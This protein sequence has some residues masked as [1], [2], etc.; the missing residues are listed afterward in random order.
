[1]L[2]NR[3][4]KLIVWYGML[5]TT[6]ILLFV[7]IAPIV[8]SSTWLCSNDF[9]TSIEISSTL[10]ALMVGFTCMS[11][12]YGLKHRFLFIIGLGFTLCGSGD[13]LHGLLPLQHL[14]VSFGNN[15]ILRI[16]D[17]YVTSRIFLAIM[18]LLALSRD[19]FLDDRKQ[20]PM[21]VFVYSF[22]AIIL[23][24]GI[25]QLS[26]LLPARLEIVSDKFVVRPVDLL[27][28]TLL[29]VAFLNL[30][31]RF[32]KSTD[33]FKG[34]L[35]AS[36]VCNLSGQIYMAFSSR[37]NDAYFSIAHIA[38][39]LS[40][41]MPLIGILIQGM[42]EINT[43]NLEIQKREAAQQ[44]LK[45]SEANYRSII[46]NIRD[47]F[48]RTDLN[49]KLTMI[50]PS[51]AKLCGYQSVDDM[52]GLDF[53]RDMYVDPAQRSYFLDELKKHGEVINYEV[54]LK[55]MDGS[56]LPV[57][58]N[59]HYRMDENGTPLYVEGILVDITER[60]KV[61]K[62]LQRSETKFRTLYE[63]TTD[64]VMLLDEKGFF[65]CNEATLHMFNCQ[66]KEQF[67]KCHPADLSSE[68]QPCGTNSLK[69]A[70]ERI[71]VAMQHGSNRFEWIHKTLD[72]KEFPAEVLLNRMIFD[73]KHVLQAVVRDITERKQMEMDIQESEER[74]KKILEHL[75]VGIVLVEAETN[76]IVD[77]NS[78]AV[79]MIGADTEQILGCSCYKFIC[80]NNQNCPIRDLG[81]SVDNAERTLVRR[82][83]TKVDVLKTVVPIHIMD[84]LYYIESFVDITDQKLTEAK[85]QESQANLK[86][87]VENTM[88]MIWAVDNNYCL[89]T[90]N[91]LFKDAVGSQYDNNLSSGTFLLDPDQIGEEMAETWKSFYDRA[92][93]DES[94]TIE[95]PPSHDGLIYETSFN[96]IYDTNGSVI[97]VSVFSRD[98]TERK[99][100]EQ[101]LQQA[102]IE[103]E[104]N[105]ARLAEFSNELEMKNLQL[106]MALHDAEAASKAKGDFLANMSHEI[107]TPMNAIIGMTELALKTPLTDKQ[108]RYL[109]NVKQA[110]SSL[111]QLI[112]DILDFSKIE[113]GK[114]EI[115]KSDFNLPEILESCLQTLA[116]QAQQKNL[117]L[118]LEIQKD[119]PLNIKGDESRLRQIFI[120]LVGNAIK[121]TDQGEIVLSVERLAATHAGSAE[122]ID[123]NSIVLQ[124]FVSDTGM[125]IPEDKLESIFNSFE[126]VD[127]SHTRKHG[128]T[129]LGLAITKRLVE[130]MGGTIRAESML[131]MG[132]TFIFTAIFELSE[133][134]QLQQKEYNFTGC[135]ALIVDDNY[136]SRTILNKMIRVWGFE[137]VE[138]ENGIQALERL[139]AAT[140][141]GQLFD[142][143]LI[144]I[145]MP[146]MD[147][148]ELSRQLCQH[149]TY[150][151]I[152]R[153]IVTANEGLT[154]KNIEQELQLSG[155]FQKP[156]QRQE[157]AETLFV[158]L[159]SVNSEQHADV[160]D[161]IQ[162]IQNICLSIL[163]TED[164]I[165]NQEL[166]VEILQDA[167]HKVDVANNGLEAINILGEKEYD[168][169]LMDVQ[170]PQMDGFEA[171]RRIRN[172]EAI[173]LFKRMPIIAMTA[174]AM[175]GDKENCLKAGMDDY[176]SKPI[177]IN[178]LLR[179][180]KKHTN[181]NHPVTQP[182]QTTN[183]SET[184][185][186][187]AVIDK[188]GALKNLNGNEKLYNK[189][190]NTFLKNAPLELEKIVHS[191][192]EN[193]FDAVKLHAHTLKGMSGT[194]GANQLYSIAYEMEMKAKDSSDMSE[195]Q[196]LSEGMINE[197]HKTAEYL[198]QML[199]G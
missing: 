153:I 154:D 187:S 55:R 120:N 143:A 192:S 151:N 157:I 58:A 63:S 101:A 141:E 50:N 159:K 104:A 34:M 99:H 37:P 180:I 4:N 183:E 110:A 122:S 107:R 30:L 27:T 24:V 28:V 146:V 75:Q 163:L 85:L 2:M 70:N 138:A 56:T 181:V 78:K 48:Y 126:Q 86:T 117:E 35:L 191:I 89:L 38:G 51:G 83:G 15:A 125:G 31:R 148:I 194:I 197:L 130:M 36:I 74:L 39:F 29:A 42:K 165:M 133:E 166:A 93:A 193:D 57:L 182:V 17:S 118:L 66:T 149:P 26:Y 113:A 7:L 175:K 64:S 19:R 168:I 96:P 177:Q 46:E 20:I 76:T 127:G 160:V 167:G 112:N 188:A 158:A 18:I 43:A 72:N 97:G 53:A 137:T 5:Y 10:I 179:I 52:I 144:D 106:D 49:G 87:V 114:L 79:E 174:H 9:H 115:K 139:E 32:L 184:Y 189:V 8:A 16:S 60:K 23:S 1:M 116:F 132:S 164:N 111:L 150:K 121:F 161:N 171:T 147:G 123:A 80:V 109:E 170:M 3:K 21:V 173:G 152:K 91:S 185:I 102:K 140:S 136:I 44:A 190:S 124:F 62:A 172:A 90:A 155:F 135:R 77:V 84:R 108:K 162:N 69:L 81:K 47:I 71:E 103:A 12:F 145:Q 92:L 119:V 45:K 14:V 73:D 25:M 61:E 67:C 41:I 40:Y 100:G 6:I 54:L 186:G 134:N 142:I 11:Y 33:V 94:F 105:A 176:I 82:D 198:Q 68:T 13:L 128:G 196:K 95:L 59:S 129:G 88:D 98:I 65:D 131:E 178:E 22:A 169:I 199:T 156:Y 195:I